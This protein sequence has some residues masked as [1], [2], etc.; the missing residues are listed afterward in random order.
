M[1]LNDRLIAGMRIVAIPIVVTLVVVVA[2][3]LV[4]Q[5]N[6]PDGSGTGGATSVRP[7]GIPAPLNVDAY[8][9]NLSLTR[10]PPPGPP[11][12]AHLVIKS[13]G[14][15]V[16]VVTVAVDPNGFL[17]VPNQYAGYWAMSASLDKGSNT[18]I[19]GHNQSGSR[20]V[21]LTLD[22]VAAGDAI[23]ITDQFGKTYFYSV[24]KTVVIKVDSA[25]NGQAERPLDYVQPTPAAQL[26][27]L[28]CY[29]ENACQDRFVVVARPSS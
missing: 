5:I 15:D 13:V 2:I 23:T 19:V 21:F 20:P 25:S 22:H 9:L 6:G 12:P 8:L 14:I 10:T 27:L 28:T 1:R 16:L 18:V 29:P 26:T 17:V 3:V 24:S 11:H 4:Q 7:T